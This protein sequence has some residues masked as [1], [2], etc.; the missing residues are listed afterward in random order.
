MSVIKFLLA[1]V[2]FPAV[3]TSLV[4]LSLVFFDLDSWSRASTITFVCWVV[5]SAV[6]FLPR[7]EK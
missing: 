2:A 1:G 7:G 3:L 6:A 5:I 4:T